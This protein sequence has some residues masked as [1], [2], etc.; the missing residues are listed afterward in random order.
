MK[1]KRK[2]QLLEKVEKAYKGWLKNI[3]QNSTVDDIEDTINIISNTLAFGTIVI[4]GKNSI[5]SYIGTYSQCK[6]LKLSFDGQIGAIS[7]VWYWIGFASSEEI[8]KIV[9]N[10]KKNLV[11]SVP[12]DEIECATL[13]FGEIASLDILYGCNK[14]GRISYIGGYKACILLRKTYGGKISKINNHWHWI[15]FADFDNA[16]AIYK[17]Y[18]K[19]TSRFRR[20]KIILTF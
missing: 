15:G 14:H 13:N 18:Q 10:K 4:T 7:N 11:L 5:S 12:T 17:R 20:K 1:Q 6:K 19:K 16:E 2:N 9:E 8:S 3:N